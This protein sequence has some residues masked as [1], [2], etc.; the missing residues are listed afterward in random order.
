MAFM[1]FA[2]FFYTVPSFTFGAKSFVVFVTGGG[3]FF[4]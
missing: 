1:E 4:L 2:V 3:L